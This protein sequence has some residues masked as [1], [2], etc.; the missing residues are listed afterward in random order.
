MYSFENSKLLGDPDIVAGRSLSARTSSKR[1]NPILVTRKGHP[2]TP[3][4]AGGAPFSIVA[5]G[6]CA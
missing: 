6:G 5:A 1:R 3:A 4:A 2:R